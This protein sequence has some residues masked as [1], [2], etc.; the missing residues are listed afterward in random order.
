M[1]TYKDKPVFVLNRNCNLGDEA[2]LSNIWGIGNYTF[3]HSKS[4]FFLTIY[5]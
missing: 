3:Y 2:V 5:N 1:I 4:Y